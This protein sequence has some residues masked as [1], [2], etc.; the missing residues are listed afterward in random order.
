MWKHALCQC[1]TCSMI[2]QVA[3]FLDKPVWFLVLPDKALKVVDVF[4]HTAWLRTWRLWKK[5][6]GSKI[7]AVLFSVPLENRAKCCFKSCWSAT[8]FPRLHLSAGDSSLLRTK[9]MKTWLVSLFSWQVI[10]WDE[11][12]HDESLAWHCFLCLQV[13]EVVDFEKL[14]DYAAAFQGHDVGYCCLGTTRAKSGAVSYIFINLMSWL[15]S[16][17]L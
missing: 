4:W 3:Y 15:F 13:Q 9:H 5:P 7:K 8:S 16:I 17:L 6:S 14:D 10:S 12:H 11:I 1:T 2:A